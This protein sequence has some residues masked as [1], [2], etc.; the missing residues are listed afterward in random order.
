[1]ARVIE[2]PIHFWFQQTN[3]ESEDIILVNPDPVGV[4]SINDLATPVKAV[5][6]CAVSQDNKVLAVLRTSDEG[7]HVQLTGLM[8][9]LAKNLSQNVDASLSEM[10][11]PSN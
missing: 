6:L 1:M 5:L 8:Q 10:E 3:P 7:A 11:G 4:L 2:G 9:T